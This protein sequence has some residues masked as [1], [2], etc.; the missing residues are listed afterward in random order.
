MK[1][2][3]HTRLTHDTMTNIIL[4]LGHLSS[5]SSDTKKV[6]GNT[7]KIFERLLS[8]FKKPGSHSYIPLL[9]ASTETIGRITKDDID[10]QNRAVDEGVVSYLLLM[11]RANKFRELQLS[12]IKVRNFCDD[13]NN[14]L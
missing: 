4:T 9:A 7:P 14:R 1:L 12:A 3:Q 5:S 6:V 10:N 13:F 11:S 8:V 2:M